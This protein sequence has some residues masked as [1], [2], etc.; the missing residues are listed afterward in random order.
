[1]L[2]RLSVEA[3]VLGAITTWRRWWPC[4]PRS[5]ASCGRP[6]PRCTPGRRAPAGQ[7]RAGGLGRRA[8]ASLGE[9]SSNSSKPPSSDGLGKPERARRATADQAAQRRKPGKQPG[10]PG[11][12]LA[13]VTE[14]DQVVE[15]V[16]HRCGGCGQDLDGAVVVGLEARQVFDLPPLRLGVVEHRA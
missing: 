12:D 14:P 10:A 11:A 16:P 4:R 1:M 15:H 7:C 6:T 2:A 3:M 13:Q 9:D 5:S 8:G